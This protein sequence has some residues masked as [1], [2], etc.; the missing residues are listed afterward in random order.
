MGLTRDNQEAVQVYRWVPGEDLTA[1]RASLAADAVV[2]IGIKLGRAVALLHRHNIIHRDICP[3]NIVLDGESDPQALRPVLIDFG[4][5][6]V[7]TASMNTT[8]VGEHLA[9]EVQSQRPQW[10]K[11]ADVYGL[12]SSLLWLLH[13]ASATKVEPILKLAV[14]ES[15]SDRISIDQFLDEL[16]KLSIREHLDARRNKTWTDIMKAAGSDNSMPWF[17][18]QLRKSQGSLLGLAMGF[19]PTTFGRFLGLSDFVN[20]VLEGCP[21]VVGSL[22]QLRTPQEGRSLDPVTTLWALRNH[23]VHAVDANYRETRASVEKF[24]KMKK[25]RQQVHFLAGVKAVGDRCGLQSLTDVVALI[26]ART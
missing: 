22:K 15:A 8:M 25:E 11:K 16:T 12:G 23:H 18:E 7:V 9:P 24:R 1:R 13:P 20:Q 3:R 5:A 26:V 21:S 4:F 14:H 17:S 19:Q 2:E 10:T 6:R